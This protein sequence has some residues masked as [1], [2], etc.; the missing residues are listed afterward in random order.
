MRKSLRIFCLL[1]LILL[2]GN[3]T[4]ARDRIVI[5]SKLFKGFKVKGKSAP[6][7]IIASYSEPF[8]AFIDPSKIEAESKSISNLKNEL[9][10]IY[11]LKHVDHLTTGN[12][13]WDGK[14]KNLNATILY[15]GFSYPINFSP[16]KLSRNK[17]SLRIE[18]F[19]YK[20][21]EVP[22]DEKGGEKLIDT[23]I[24][25]NFNEPVVL[26]FPS[27]GHT[28]FL[29][30]FIAKKKTHGVIKGKISKVNK[31]LKLSQAPRPVHKVKPVYPKKCKKEIIEG[32]VILELTTDKEGSVKKIRVVKSAHP[33]L[34]NAAKE[35]LKQ[36]KY[37]PVLKKGKP[38]SAMFAVSVDFKF[39]QKIAQES[40][41]INVE[42]PVRVFKSSTFV[43]DLTIDDFEVYEDG[44]LQKLEAVYL[45]K[46]TGIERKEEKKRFT[47]NTSRN[48]YLIF[49]I[50]EYSPRIIDALNYFIQNVLMP[51]DNLFVVTPM[52]TYEMNYKAL[53][54]R[55]TEEIVNELKGLLRKD[56]MLGSSEY[57]STLEDLAKITRALASTIAV[58]DETDMT[59]KQSAFSTS[60]LGEDDKMDPL[61]RL[62]MLLT[63]YTSTLERLDLMR[64]VDQNKLLEFAE[65]LKNKEGQKYVFLFYQR[66]FI[67]QIEP[68]ILSQT[69]GLLQGQQ[70]II[71]NISDVFNLHKREISVDVNQVK[72]AYSDSSASIH[73]MFF[74][75]PAEYIPGIRFE[76]H[77][78]DIFSAFNEMARA[79]GGSTES[80]SNPNFLFKKAV[81]SSENY[82]LL[83]YAPI[84]YKKDG[85]FKQIEVKIKNKNYRISHRAGYFAK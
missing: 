77:S 11:Q 67:P 72:R 8:Y 34:D 79:T 60:I 75:K 58:G 80:S 57:R 51:G 21:T 17:V 22:L 56:A 49:Q 65:H 69:L 59:K 6:E 28:Y 48:F 43:N 23:E 12:M 35:A 47:P 13:I 76:E 26:G 36:W 45:I 31:R 44:K 63:L 42:V 30:I 14:K 24:V 46:K 29:S 38:V 32:A 1:C 54:L 84:E 20:R 85:K 68:R 78:E 27:N 61:L 71:Q 39:A 73:F 37:E 16:K 66:E 5:E 62:E 64:Y 55:S 33:D 25:L 83:Y 15:E 74:T 3:F 19:E 4:F 70:H 7:V 41:V 18:M 40:L 10:S 2:M 52:R 81:E 9:N 50:T 53:K 82:Y